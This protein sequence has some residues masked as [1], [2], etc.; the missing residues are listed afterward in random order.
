MLP[1]TGV[2]VL[3]ALC[4][5]ASV[6]L[7]RWLLATEDGN[8]WLLGHLPGVESREFSGTLA[9]SDWRLERLRVSWGGGQNWLLIEG[10]AASGLAWQWRPDDQTW[11]GLDVRALTA[12]KLTLHLG[13]AGG[14]PPDPAPQHRHPG[15]SAPGPGPAG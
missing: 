13:A 2:L 14:A 15:A 11:L 3:A 4:V 10:L 8:R 9:G 12:R 7:M 1:L 6:A 5:V